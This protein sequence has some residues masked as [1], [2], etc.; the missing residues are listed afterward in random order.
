MYCTIKYY[1]II[2]LSLFLIKTI[3]SLNYNNIRKISIIRMSRQQATAGDY[4]FI[5]SKVKSI[6]LQRGS[7]GQIQ[8]NRIHYHKIGAKR[9]VT[10]HFIWSH[11]FLVIGSVTAFYKKRF[12]LSVLIAVTTIL[13]TLYHFE[14]E[15]PSRLAKLEGISAKVL[16]IYGA[17]QTILKAPSISLSILL[18]ELLLLF[19]TLSFFLL[20][21]IY[22][23]LYDKYHCFGLHIVPSFWAIVVAMWHKPFLI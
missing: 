12:E 23:E 15:K 22:P 13:S 2:I 4:S 11:I 5:S 1:Y 17:C 20:T 19:T 21:N 9:K 16:F 6:L 3:S 8:G 10:D 7:I 14:Y 18:I